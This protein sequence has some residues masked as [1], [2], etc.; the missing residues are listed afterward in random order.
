MIAGPSEVLIIA[1]DDNNPE[2]IAWDLLS[3]AEHDEH[4]QSILITTNQG[5]GKLVAKEVEKILESLE[6]RNIA[7]R[8][9]ENFGVIISRATN[10]TQMT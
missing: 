4:A 6:R 5:L 7:G 8:S 2:W 9:W 10:V 1:D 3:Q